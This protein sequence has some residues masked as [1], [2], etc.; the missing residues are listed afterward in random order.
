MKLD[1]VTLLSVAHTLQV[2]SALDLELS[3]GWCAFRK[4]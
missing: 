2:H 1:R 4:T 3:F